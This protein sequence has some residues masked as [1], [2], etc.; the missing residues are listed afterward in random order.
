M[1]WEGLKKDHFLNKLNQKKE[2]TPNTWRDTVGHC[3]LIPRS[4]FGNI[5]RKRRGRKLNTFEKAILHRQ[6]NKLKNTLCFWFCPNMLC[7]FTPIVIINLQCLKQQKCLMVSP[8]VTIKVIWIF[9]CIHLQK[10]YTWIANDEFSIMKAIWAKDC[11]S[12]WTK[13]TLC[14]YL[15]VN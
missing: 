13:D 15:T 14:Q 3:K 1:K 7:N 8:A 2:L 4:F 10:I 12:L 11:I 6:T 5:R 9:Y